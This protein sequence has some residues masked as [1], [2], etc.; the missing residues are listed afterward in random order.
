MTIAIALLG[1][2]VGL[3]VGIVCG[4]WALPIALRSQE[5]HIRNGRSLPTVLDARRL[6]GLTTFAHRVLVPLVF[7]IT[8]AFIAHRLVTGGTP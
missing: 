3:S 6:A 7:S 4:K 5:A 1:A 8:G 2:L